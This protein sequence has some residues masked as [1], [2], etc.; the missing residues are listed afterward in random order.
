MPRQPADLS[1]SQPAAPSPPAA[2]PSTLLG[3]ARGSF[4][5]SSLLARLAPAYAQL[6]RQLAEL[7]VPEVQVGE[8][9]GCTGVL[10]RG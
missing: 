2:G 1:R 8:A 9:G 3:L 7:G 5:R 6:L 10:A 4:D